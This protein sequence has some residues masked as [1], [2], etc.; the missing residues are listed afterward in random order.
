MAD[1]AHVRIGGGVERGKRRGGRRTHVVRAPKRQRVG[2]EAKA[3]PCRAVARDRTAWER[4]GFG[5]DALALRRSDYVCPSASATFAALDAA[6]DADVRRIGHFVRS[7]LAREPESLPPLET[8]V[9]AEAGAPSA[10]RPWP[11]APFESVPLGPGIYT[12]PYEPQ[13][14][15]ESVPDP[16]VVPESAATPRWLIRA[17]GGVAATA[18]GYAVFHGLG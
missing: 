4:L 15:D 1:S 17:G 10:D 18:A 2:A 8:V 12:E 7:L 16:P 3:F 5:A 9:A 14:V 11:F 6:A 13:T